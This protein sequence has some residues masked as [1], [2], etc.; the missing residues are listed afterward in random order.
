MLVSQAGCADEP[1]ANPHARLDAAALASDAAQGGSARDAASEQQATRDGS[2]SS[3]A[4][5]GGDQAEGNEAPNLDAATL[6][7]TGMRGMLGADAQPGDGNTPAP[8]DAALADGQSA[9]AQSDTPA[10]RDCVY[11][12]CD[13]ATGAVRFWVF[14]RSASADRCYRL[15]FVYIRAPLPDLPYPEV[16]LNEDWAIEPALASAAGAN[17]SAPTTFYA[18][19][20]SGQIE[21]EVNPPQAGFGLATHVSGELALEFESDAGTHATRLRFDD[22]AIAASGCAAL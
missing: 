8:A 21:I 17:C 10:C 13:A 11:T 20:M 22:L 9:D 14:A 12:A 16:M 7:D 6:L 3:A 5:D 1:E 2:A 19:R 15:S 18:A 4:P